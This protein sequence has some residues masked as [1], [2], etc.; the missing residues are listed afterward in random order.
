[1][2]PSLPIL[3]RVQSQSNQRSLSDPLVSVVGSRA[4][5]IEFDP[6]QP[7]S[8][9]VVKFLHA[10]CTTVF[11][12]PS[13]FLSLLAALRARFL[14]CGCLGINF[15]HVLFRWCGDIALVV[16]FFP[17]A[18]GLLAIYLI[19]AQLPNISCTH[20]RKNTP[21]TMNSSVL[22]PQKNMLRIDLNL[23]PSLEDPNGNSS[24]FSISSS[25]IRMHPFLY[26][27]YD[28]CAHILRVL[29]DSVCLSMWLQVHLI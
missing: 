24:S 25:T 27:K 26:S 6:S 29:D 10:P 19:S 18:F 9:F 11:F 21:S 16:A 15:F 4:R 22:A 12:Y 3:N 28:A 23:E 5:A 20:A 8:S 2:F 13:A 17:V 7:H 14:A 1:M